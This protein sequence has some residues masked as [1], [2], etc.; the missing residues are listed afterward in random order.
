ML[1][2]GE[3]MLFH[4]VVSGLRELHVCLVGIA[5]EALI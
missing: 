5:Q 2:A 3:W 1:D 4:Y